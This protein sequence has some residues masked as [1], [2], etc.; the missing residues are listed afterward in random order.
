MFTAISVLSICRHILQCLVLGFLAGCAIDSSD[1]T[2]ASAGT[3]C[4]SNGIVAIRDNGSSALVGKRLDQAGFCF[5]DKERY[6]LKGLARTHLF[7]GSFEVGEEHVFRFQGFLSQTKPA[8]IT[9]LD[10]TGPVPISDVRQVTWSWDRY[11]E[12]PVG[13]N[14]YTTKVIQ[15]RESGVFTSTN[16]ADDIVTTLWFNQELGAILKITFDP[17]RTIVP[18]PASVYALGNWAA[19]WILCPDS[20]PHRCSGPLR[21]QAPFG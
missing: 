19:I 11:E 16:G 10:R 18:L 2:I 21:S 13:G 12:L 8:S 5:S 15:R 7:L 3:K 17:R 20:L 6:L 4:G 14:T 1:L 9:Y